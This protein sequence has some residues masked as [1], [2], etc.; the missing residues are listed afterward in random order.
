MRKVT[1]R[2][3]CFL[4]SLILVTINMTVFS[5]DT[6][7][8]AP[9]DAPN[10]NIAASYGYVLNDYINE[11][12]VIS[13]ENPN[14]YWG[15]SG[16]PNGLV[17]ADIV[18]FENNELPCLVLFLASAATKS[19]ECHIWGYDLE[20]NKP[21]Q[22]TS[23]SKTLSQ[24]TDTRGQF[25]IGW[26]NDKRYVV[27]HTL[28]N[29]N[30]QGNYFTVINSEAF[31]YVNPP[32]GVSEA[33]VMYFNKEKIF[34]D[35]DISGYN[36][37]LTVF[38]DKLKNAAADSVTYEEVTDTISDDEM[39]GIESAASKASAAGNFDILNYSTLES[40]EDA[41]NSQADGDKFYLVSNV[42]SL[43]DEMYYVR[44]STDRSFY[45]YTL[46]RH[47]ERDEKYQ[48]LKT[49]MD[50]IPLSDRELTITYNEYKRSALLYKKAKS[51]MDSYSTTARVPMRTD[52]IIKLPKLF[53]LPKILDGRIKKPA[54]FISS[55]LTILLI[56]GLWVFMYSYDDEN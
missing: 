10:E 35:V 37:A 49:R 31:S 55:A 14:G 46:L 8:D 25:A 12:G 51:T 34:S 11:Y 44:F 56:T 43:G 5:A 1:K 45:N 13:S 26:N 9:A 27:Y 16:I 15:I 7:D 41:L 39:S 4:C 19:V 42:Y 36:K 3:L 2:I 28:D 38:F 30:L 24:F 33:S 52:S 48:I 22:I 54:V 40:Y 6:F 47:T 50:C 32:V 18:N 29:D 20:H 21:R 17:Y 23:I 53:H